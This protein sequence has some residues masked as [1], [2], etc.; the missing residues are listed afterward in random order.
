[1]RSIAGARARAGRELMVVAGSNAM[2]PLRAFLVALADLRERCR[3]LEHAI[4]RLDAADIRRSAAEVLPVWARAVQTVQNVPSRTSIPYRRLARATLLL[5]HQE[6][7]AV[8]QCGILQGGEAGLPSFLRQ[9]EV[10][11]GRPFAGEGE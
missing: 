2:K 9:I 10:Q 4:Q 7:C 3:S 5:A 1:M 8:L 6:L 11:L